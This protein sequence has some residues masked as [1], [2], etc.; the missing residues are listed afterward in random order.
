VKKSLN[1]K[2]KEVLREKIK[3]IRIERFSEMN[4]YSKKTVVFEIKYTW[5]GKSGSTKRSFRE[6]GALNNDLKGKHKN[7]PDFP[8]KK[9]QTTTLTLAD[10]EERKK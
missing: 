4:K 10:L 1:V 7:M 5:C 6:F 9:D 2:Y 8:S 3:N